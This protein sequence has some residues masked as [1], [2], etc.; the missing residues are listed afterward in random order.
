MCVKTMSVLLT[1][2]LL[3]AASQLATRLKQT[4]RLPADH[5]QSITVSSNTRP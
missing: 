3:A 4:G 1:F 5:H 2:V